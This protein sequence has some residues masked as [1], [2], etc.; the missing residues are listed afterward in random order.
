MFSRSN[1]FY[2]WLC[3][4]EVIVIAGLIFV[5]AGRDFFGSDRQEYPLLLPAAE[6]V[7][8]PESM[9]STLLFAGDMMFSRSIAKQIE[10]EQDPLYPF[11][12]IASTTSAANL[13]FANLET[14][15]SASGT[16]QGSIYS[17]RAEPVGTMNALQYAGVDV[18]SLA[19][20]HI[21]DYGRVAALDTLKYLREAGIGY[22]GFGRN[23]DEANE[24]VV[25]QVGEAKV[26]FLGYT[27]FYSRALWADDRLGLSEFEPT[28]IAKRIGALKESAKADLV[29]VSLHWGEEYKTEANATQRKIAHQLVDAGA[30]LIIGHHPHVPQE[31]E[32][33]KD[34]YIIY[35]LGNFVFD[36]NFSKDTK[37]GLM[38]KVVLEGKKIQSAQ[39][40]EIGFTKTYQP[41][42]LTL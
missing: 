23:H 26:A 40:L 16:L 39:T 31:F 28:P 33:Y 27:E 29:V 18:V 36:Q 3:T 17:F 1:R 14:P 11:L 5:L 24:P 37:H 32:R 4:V 34:G 20:N 21:W 25:R 9:T 35:S 15:V 38:L 6:E 2:L 13:M 10:R 8:A 12:L 30:D 19:N 42:I 22:V 41:Y 7:A